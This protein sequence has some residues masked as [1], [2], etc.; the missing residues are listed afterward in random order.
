MRRIITIALGVIAAGSMWL[1]PVQAG[2]VGMPMGLQSAI[3]RIKLETPTLPPMA[4]TQ[5]C[6]RYRGE[7][8]TRPMFRGG[9]ARL[10]EERWADLKEINQVVNRGIAPERNER[11]VAGEQWLIN[12]ARGDCN[13]Y[14]VSKRHELLE[15]G[16]PA[17]AL[18]LSEVMVN[19][20]EHHLILV[21]RTNSG[22]LVL[23][24]MTSQ[25]KSW[26]RVPYRWVR[27]QMPNSKLWAT[28]SSARV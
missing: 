16:W 18:L 28:I 8:R 10:T 2:L 25:I 19:S 4:F 17:R 22:D 5:F 3:Q 1:E 24:N 7:C 12:P 26:S 9:P 15:R 11:G 20:G 14:A 13:D 23:D 6:H 27:M 21:V